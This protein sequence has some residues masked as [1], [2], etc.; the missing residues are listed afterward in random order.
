MPNQKQGPGTK[1]LMK[2]IERRF[3]ELA[4]QNRRRTGDPQRAFKDSDGTLSMVEHAIC[5][6][7]VC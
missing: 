6:R 1:W 4:E 2:K 7:H 5:L 3:P